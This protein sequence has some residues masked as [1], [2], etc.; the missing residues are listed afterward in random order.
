MLPEIKSENA[1]SSVIGVMLMLV[2]TIIIAA[3]VAA[4]AA[5]IMTESEPTSGAMVKQVGFSDS[6]TLQTVTDSR[7]RTGDAKLGEI[8]FVFEV[9]GGTLDLRNL[10]MTIQGT[11]WGSAGAATLT[12]DDP[13]A[14]NYIYPS[15]GGLCTRG[16]DPGMILPNVT[17]DDRARMVKY[18]SGIS[19]DD[20]SDP[21]LQSGE[22]FIVLVEYYMP[23]SMSI[24]LRSD[25]GTTDTTTWSSGAISLANGE[26]AYYDLTDLVTGVT[27]SS[28]M[29]T[30]DDLI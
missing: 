22:R 23:G 24:G 27:Y 4:C 6:Y 12:Y 11:A 26:A 10:R 16:I 19:L 13:I 18:G 3:V 17:A 9:T 7:G 20:K 8:G 5:G 29:I 28:G 14:L 1:V 2:V 30:S 15:S 21:V 25:R